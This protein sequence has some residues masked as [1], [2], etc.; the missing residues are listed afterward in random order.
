M[1]NFKW[2]CKYTVYL[3]FICTYTFIE[4]YTHY[5]CLFSM[6]PMDVLRISSTS[7]CDK[8]GMSCWVK[9]P[10]TRGARGCLP[11]VAVVPK[12]RRSSS[13][14]NCKP[15]ETYH[16]HVSNLNPRPIVVKTGLL[17]FLPSLWG[18]LQEF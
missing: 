7:A 15:T 16:Y 11:R 3:S 2:L 6:F 10:T 12:K 8:N 14:H 13:H 1:I 5:I 9:K 4:A 17:R 18:P